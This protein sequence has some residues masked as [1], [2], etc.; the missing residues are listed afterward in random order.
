MSLIGRG[1]SWQESCERRG[2]VS[3]RSRGVWRRLP[4]GG[5]GTQRL[6]SAALCIVMPWRVGCSQVD[7]AKPHSVKQETLARHS[8]QDGWWRRR[9]VSL[10][11]TFLL[12]IC[13][14]RGFPWA[15]LSFLQTLEGTLVVHRSY[16]TNREELRYCIPDSWTQSMPIPRSVD[17]QPS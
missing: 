2:S 8:R 12:S 1:W 5:L 7:I 15:D 3:F 9:T 13:C 10:F 17:H 6:I 11:W 4:W 14:L 16:F